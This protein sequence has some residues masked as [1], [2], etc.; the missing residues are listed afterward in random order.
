MLHV[1]YSFTFSES[2]KALDIFLETIHDCG[3]EDFL[4]RMVQT[5]QTDYAHCDANLYLIIIELLEMYNLPELIVDLATTAID[6]AQSDDPNVVCINGRYANVDLK[7]LPT[8][9]A[10]SKESVSVCD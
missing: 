7:W 9:L 5:E 6:K 2:H 8:K 10:T 4:L 3:S 1:L